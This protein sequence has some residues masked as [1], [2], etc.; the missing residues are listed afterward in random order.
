MFTGGVTSA[1][2]F[3]IGMGSGPGGLYRNSRFHENTIELSSSQWSEDFAL[4]DGQKRLYTAVGYAHTDGRYAYASWVTNGVVLGGLYNSNDA[5]LIWKFSAPPGNTFSGGTVE[6]DLTIMSGGADKADCGTVF[7]LGVSESLSLSSAND[8]VAFSDYNRTNFTCSWFSATGADS[9]TL[10][11]NI[12]AGASSF[13]VAVERGIPPYLYKQAL[14]EGLRVNAQFAQTAG[15]TIEVDQTEPIWSTGDGLTLDVTATGGTISSIDWTLVDQFDDTVHAS[16]TETVVG[17]VATIDLSSQYAGFYTLDVADSANP[18]SVFDYLDIVILREQDASLGADDTIFGAFGYPAYMGTEG[19][20]AVPVAEDIDLM[21]KMGVKWTVVA[22]AQWPSCQPVEN[23]PIDFSYIPALQTLK[24]GGLEIIMTA[25][26]CPKWA[27]NNAGNRYPPIP[28]YYD[29]YQAYHAAVAEALTNLVTWHQAW[30]EPNNNGQLMLS[31]YTR[32]GAVATAKTLGRLQNEAVKLGNSNSKFIGGC[33]AGIY[34][35]W[36]DDLLEAPNSL[37][38][39]QDA[40]ST[41]PYPVWQTTANGTGHQTP[42]EPDLVPRLQAVQDVL[43]QHGQQELPTFWTEF[44]WTRGL[45]T[46]EEYAGW[47]ARELVIM[48]SFLRD[49]NVGCINLFSF[50]DLKLDYNVL[51]RAQDVGAQQTRCTKVV[52]SFATTASLLAGAQPVERLRDYP[53]P[54]RLYSF[55]N[56]SGD[57]I[58]AAW[59]TEDAVYPFSVEL[60][61]APGTALTQISMMG[62]EEQIFAPDGALALPV[63]HDPVYWV[64]SNGAPW[65]VDAQTVLVEDN[66]G[67][68][69]GDGYG[70]PEPGER[71]GLQVLVE[72]LDVFGCS[73]LTATLSC[74]DSAVTLVD[75]ELSF[76]TLA[77][78]ESKTNGLF[79]VDISSSASLE[80]IVDFTLT[81]TGDSPGG[82]VSWTNSFSLKLKDM[83]GTPNTFLFSGVTYVNGDPVEGLTINYSNSV[84]FV[85]QEIGDEN[86]AYSFMAGDGLFYYLTV[87]YQGQTNNTYR[88]ILSADRIVNFYFTVDDDGPTVPSLQSPSDGQTGLVWSVTFDW[89]AATDASGVSGYQIRIDS[90]VYDAGSATSCV[91]TLSTGEHFW[92]VRAIDTLGNIGEWSAFRSFTVAGGSG[93]LTPPAMPVVFSATAVDYSQIDLSWTDSSDNEDGFI[94]NRR[95][96]GESVFTQ[97]AT[98]G[99]NVTSHSDTGLSAATEYDYKLKAYNSAGDSGEITVTCETPSTN[100][101]SAPTGFTATAMGPDQIDLGW[102]DTSSDETGFRITR[103]VAG[104]GGYTQIVSLAAGTTSYSDT[105]LSAETLYEYRVVSYNANGDSSAAEASATTATNAVQFTF[106]GNTYVDWEGTSGISVWYTAEN[107]ESGSMISGTNGYYSFPVTDGVMYYIHA[108]YGGVTNSMQRRI[109]GEDRV[110]QYFNFTLP[111]NVP[112]APTGLTATAMGPDQIDLSWTD[113]SSDETGFRIACQVDGQGG[114]TQIV[115]LAAGTTNYSNTG[116][117]EGTLYE[118]RVV[119]YNVN[120]DSAAAEASATTTSNAVQYTFSGKTFVNTVGTSGI[121]VWYTAENDESGSMTSGTDGYYSFPVTDGVMYYIHATYGGVTNSM[122]RR[123]LSADRVNQNF[124]FTE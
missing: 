66:T 36:F 85:G 46:E 115:S 40:I 88:K 90:L 69:S 96:A 73:N 62:A 31:P 81:L 123:I 93:G 119:A 32:T 9:Q 2:D 77:V 35:S 98:L 11:V 48:M 105:G 67:G 23:G 71:I 97:I 3:F 27:N 49:L 54:V 17:G 42:P 72:N 70:D 53:D 21:Q 89:A 94:L 108:T 106:S 51:H 63:S 87:V 124:W 100:A 18:L 104:Q 14:L 4:E 52:G 1:N 8:Y 111:T 39:H 65:L 99:S 15:L 68:T 20:F 56:R 102:T 38:G 103:Q 113:N 91:K 19:Q 92:Q 30:N 50:H 83:G 16:G 57:L 41:H 109:L 44:G 80:H 33:M 86:G 116:L 114:Y 95:A 6:V 84:G 7:S 61:V 5:A 64:V 75:D 118:Y 60:P 47:T 59:A 37:I 74:S 107:N 10:S 26:G 34:D 120:G 43:A 12:P 45:V 58:Y 122:Q 24:D 110:N 29:E 78:D 28:A 55:K 79:L 117:S 25:D 112:A 13:F 22:Q 76:G 82:S 101:P 121:S